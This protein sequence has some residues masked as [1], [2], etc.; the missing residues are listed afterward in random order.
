MSIQTASAIVQR[1]GPCRIALDR[2]LFADFANELALLGCDPIDLPR[3][4]AKRRPGKTIGFLDWPGA[5]I[6]KPFA[7]ALRAYAGMDALVLQSAGQQRHALEQALF[8]AGWQRHP[9]GMMLHEFGGWSAYFLPGLTYYSRAVQGRPGALRSSGGEADALI[10][11][12]AMAATHA[13]PGDHLLVDSAGSADGA[14][15]L[16]ALSRAG[17][18]SR[19]GEDRAGIKPDLA[20]V[21]DNSVDMIVA[22]E[23]I[24]PG[25]WTR[26]L[27]DYARILKCDGR[28]ILGWRRS[29]GSNARPGDW[30][31]LVE[32]ASAYFLPESRQLLGPTS[33]DLGGPQVIQSAPFDQDV[34]LD[35][36][37]L[38]ASANP[39]AGEGRGADYDHPAFPK[40]DGPW[41]ALVDFGA[42]YDNPYLYRAMV[43][44]GERL[45]HDV[46]L[47]RLA[48]CVI[49]DAR[50]DSADRGAALAVLGYRVLEMR[51]PDLAAPVLPVIA[52]YAQQ[53]L[54][55]APPHVRRW[56]IS[57]AF[58]AGRLAELTGD[59]AAARDW[60][61]RAALAQ[62]EDFSPLLATK[63][64]A[65]S[66]YEARLSLAD[67]DA[68][69]ARACFQRGLDT[70]LSAAA[71]PHAQQIGPAEHPLSF[72]MTEL[73]EVID[74]GS[75]CANALTHFHLWARDP[76]LFW[77]QVD[78]RRFGLA[79]WARDLER[80]NDRLRAA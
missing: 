3:P 22:I 48:E 28:I 33:A 8:D 66:F 77:R 42:A 24:I 56:A 59:R 12:Y 34:D 15:I 61:H 21:A 7:Q 10:A 44:M 32:A 79:S 19:T 76:G 65:A 17:S 72:Y 31:T 54:D 62:W 52:A 46:T 13:R 57:L 11:R 20:S 35:W 5:E 75:Q 58:L 55:D 45:S 38:I 74:M 47:A 49:E 67:G 2:S 41:P 23:P 27:A 25:D 69:A 26:R 29:D 68:A 63:A 71:F 9:A 80:E 53:P 14:S 43:Q 4:G 50:P 60:Y 64:I 6:G 1:L 39:L 73:A 36:M 18:V 78:V 37:I 16:A 70:A 51:L 40:T 30:A